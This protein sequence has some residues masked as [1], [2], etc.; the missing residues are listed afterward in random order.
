MGGTTSLNAITDEEIERIS[1]RQMKKAAFGYVGLVGSTVPNHVET[2]SKCRCTLCR[3]GIELNRAGKAVC[4]RCSRGSKG[5]DR[6]I[7]SVVDE[8]AVRK[9]VQATATADLIKARATAQRFRR[10][11]SRGPTV[12]PESLRI[13]KNTIKA[14][15]AKRGE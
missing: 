2:E 1:I 7:K 3:N 12:N 5:L 11:S 14:E 4:L 13:V 8:M 9:A 10:G 15:L 6:A